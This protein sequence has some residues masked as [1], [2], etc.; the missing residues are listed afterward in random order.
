MKVRTVQFIDY[1]FGVPLCFVVSLWHHLL[2]KW[3]IPSPGTPRKIL[4]VELSEIHS[5]SVL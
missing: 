5:P 2:G 1:W 4:F 3:L